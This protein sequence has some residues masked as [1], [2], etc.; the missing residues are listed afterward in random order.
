VFRGATQTRVLLADPA[1]GNVTMSI[2]R[3]TRGWIEYAEVGRVGFVVTRS[4][5]LALPGRLKAHA[6]DFAVLR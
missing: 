4:G 3:F 2:P 6:R 5:Q 1:F